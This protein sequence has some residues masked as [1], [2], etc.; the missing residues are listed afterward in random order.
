MALIIY[1]LLYI[2]L[3]CQLV[4]LRRISLSTLHL[5]VCKHLPCSTTYYTI[6]IFSSYLET[7]STKAVT[8]VE[9]DANG[10]HRK[11]QN[12]QSEDLC[13][14]QLTNRRESTLQKS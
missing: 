4:I 11:A 9:K 7:V 2:Y 6:T 10:H 8:E 12:Y 5:I 14:T 13:V 1:F 3:N